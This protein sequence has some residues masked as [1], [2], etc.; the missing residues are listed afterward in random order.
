LHGLARWL[1]KALAATR[2]S[3]ALDGMRV[4]SRGTRS[5]PARHSA[6]A[7]SR[8]NSMQTRCICCNRGDPDRRQGS[9]VSPEQFPFALEVTVQPMALRL[10]GFAV[11]M[12]LYFLSPVLGAAAL[13]SG[14]GYAVWQRKQMSRDVMETES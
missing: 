2:E 14:F 1:G 9:C 6:A 8:R 11:L 12:L 4:F 7:A 13:V 5:A 10:F 3:V